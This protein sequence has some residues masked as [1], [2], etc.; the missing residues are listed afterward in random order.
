MIEQ[1]YILLIMNCKKYEKKSEI[2]KNTWL[3]SIPSYLKYYHVIGDES[4]EELYT[5]DE[6]NNILYVKTPDDYNSLPNKVISS[7]NAIYNKFN[8]KYIFKTDDDQILINNNFFDILVKLLNNKEKKYHYGGFIVDVKDNYLSQYHKIH[9]ELPNYLPVLQTRYCNGR[10][11]FLSKSS[12]NQLI[13][14]KDKIKKEYLE[15]YAI[16]YNLDNRFKENILMLTTNKFF[17]DIE[18]SAY[19]NLLNYK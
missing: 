15:D 18:T 12:V 5:F 17:I 4:L 6:T 8:F 14:K 16:G 10:F 19:K 11:Y 3:K 13:Y 2:Q 7:Y 9:P 1:E